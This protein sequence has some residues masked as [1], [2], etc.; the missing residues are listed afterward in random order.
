MNLLRP[1]T[2]APRLLS[3]AAIDAAESTTSSQHRKS[4]FRLAGESFLTG[5]GRAIFLGIAAGAAGICLVAYVYHSRQAQADFDG[6]RRFIAVR[7]KAVKPP[8][9]SAAPRMIVQIPPESLRVT[10]IALGHPR[11]AVLNG[12]EVTEGDAI[13]V[14]ASGVEATLRVLKIA[15]R[16][17]DLTDGTQIITTRMLDQAY[18]SAPKR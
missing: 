8:Q 9:P 12:K 11:L 15:D 4:K 3:T 6:T 2:E 7:T 14:Q 17:I 10:A 5:N 18:R 16:S 13:T 1:S